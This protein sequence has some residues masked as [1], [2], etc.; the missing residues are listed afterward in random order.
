MRSP[1][2][3]LSINVVSDFGLNGDGKEDNTEKFKR[4]FDFVA[5]QMI[6][7]RR[8]RTKIGEPFG[9][10]IYIPPGLYITGPFNLTSHITI[11]MSPNCTIKAIDTPDNFPLIEPLPSYGQG[12]DFEGPRRAPFIGG[13]SLKDVVITKTTHDFKDNNNATIDGSG[14]NWWKNFVSW[15]ENRPH[16]IEFHSCDGILME[17]VIFKNSPFWTIHPV[18]SSNVIARNIIIDNQSPDPKNVPPRN[19]DGFDPDSS[20]NVTYTDSISI[21]GDDGVAIKSGWDCFG[22][23]VNRPS[24]NILISNLTI[25]HASSA[26]IA[27]GS[28]MSGGVENVVVESSNFKDVESGVRIKTSFGRGGYVKNVRLSNIN[29]KTFSWQGI[30]IGEDYGALNPSCPKPNPN[31]LL[32]V[33]F[34]NDISF[35]NMNVATFSNSIQSQFKSLSKVGGSF[36]GLKKFQA[37][38]GMIR[39]VLLANVMVDVD[40]TTIPWTCS[41]VE[42]KSKN[43]FP[44]ICKQLRQ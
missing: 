11:S 27:I 44:K 40:N 1:R 9:V 10:E 41:A 24:K 36:Q 17:N 3:K 33:P 30:Q 14:F 37:S 12:R 22:I 29:I 32:F 16:L 18:Y 25:L 28:E 8:K 19:T 20:I 2:R 6:K 39:N 43:V 34:V 26:G 4:V 38:K 35:I 13:F 31:D 15:R 21:T 42:G 7:E 5:K 23:K